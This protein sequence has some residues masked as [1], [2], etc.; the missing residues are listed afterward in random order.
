ML[1]ACIFF[2]CFLLAVDVCNFVC[3][4]YPHAL[5]DL[6]EALFILVVAVVL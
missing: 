2:V 6:D 1:S 3:V 5:H 4:S